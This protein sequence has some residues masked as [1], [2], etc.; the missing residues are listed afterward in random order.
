MNIYIEFLKKKILFYVEIEH[1][2]ILL[3]AWNIFVCSQNNSYFLY[4]FFSCSEYFSP[5]TL[6]FVLRKK[7]ILMEHLY[8]LSRIIFF[9]ECFNCSRTITNFDQ[10]IFPSENFCAQNNFLHLYLMAQLIGPFILLS[11]GLVGFTYL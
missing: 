5:R 2:G 3:Y 7:I 8:F 10:N 11:D 9:L 4:E 1:G 6:C